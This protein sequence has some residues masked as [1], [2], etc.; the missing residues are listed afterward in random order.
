MFER[1]KETERLERKWRRERKKTVI[2]TAC[3]EKIKGERDEVWEELR[4]RDK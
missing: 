2:M 4:E 1:E 3:K